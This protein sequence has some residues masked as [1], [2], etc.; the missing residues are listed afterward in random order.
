LRRV[1]ISVTT[2]LAGHGTLALVSTTRPLSRAVWLATM[3]VLAAV[4]FAGAGLVVTPAARAATTTCNPDVQLC[5]APGVQFSP[6][7][8]TTAPTPAEPSPGHPCWTDYATASE[9]GSLGYAFGSDGNP[10][11][12]RADNPELQ[13]EQE[14]CAGTLA[15]SG[16]QG[17]FA[18][19]GFNNG[20][21]LPCYLQVTSLAFRAWNR[22]LA[23][24]GQPV[25]PDGLPAI[26]GATVAYGVWLYNGTDWFPDPTFPGSAVCPGSTI[27]WAGKL[28]YWLI[29]S[30][31]DGSYNSGPQTTLC[32][33]DGVN[34]QWEPL[35]LPAATIARLPVGQNGGNP[36]TIG[37]ITS[38][39]CYAWDNC[40]FFGTDGIEVHWD[41]QALSDVSPSPAATPWL[42]GDFTGAVA[43]TDSAGQQFGLAVAASGMTTSAG[44]AAPVPSA[45]DGSPP[46]QLFGSQGGPFEPLP[47]SPPATPQANDPFTTDLADI[48]ANSV[49]DIWISGDPAV[50]LSGSSANPAPLLPLTGTGS[51]ASC[52]GYDANTVPAPFTR[53]T[54]IGYQWTGLSTFPDGSAL[55]SAQYGSASQFANP[56]GPVP[57]A[58]PALV[59]AACGQAPVVT[60]FHR[61]DPLSADQNPQTAP[62]IPAD[63]GGQ[64]TA[65]AA[66]ASND[67]WAATSDGR[68][69]FAFQGNG[70]L[71][72]HLY[73]WTDGQFVEAPAGDDNESRP[74]LFTLGPPVF[75]IGAPTIVVTPGPT[76][77]TTKKQK[78]KK[79]KLLPAV[80]S[81]H[82]KLVATGH[83]TYTLY[84]TFK[85]RRKVKIGVQALKGKKVVASSGIKRFTGHSGQLA[86]KLSRNAWPTGLRW[87][88]PKA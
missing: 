11:D 38:G 83:G 3:V 65:V 13:S 77:T 28:D 51:P 18:G 43:G 49:G 55:A 80:Y 14:F 66:N 30:A 76:T 52:P 69:A 16:W 54:G 62:A 67:A 79:V 8:T 34:L 61:P 9:S 20:V 36:I 60:E 41:G 39:A 23:A 5:C 50:R 47:Y 58:E 87:V 27:L 35:S 37:G 29:G 57:D 25:G 46:A 74:S 84:L 78:T 40:W 24:T 48:S 88:T 10:V 86:L 53:R 21:T 75:Q 44:I 32:R 31:P 63:L 1:D 17:D 33:F 68:W 73:H 19:T 81:V 4:A 82:S 56:Q 12:L 6:G 85:V 59:Y 72:P 70:L 7:Q 22:G 64:P 45:P 2:W 42:E 15:G 26:H 71:A